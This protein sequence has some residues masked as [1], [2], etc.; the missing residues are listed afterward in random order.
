MGQVDFF[1]AAFPQEPFNLV[2]AI[3]EG[4]GSGDGA[5]IGGAL[6]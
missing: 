6:V 5:G 1:L 2:A 4:G 3:G